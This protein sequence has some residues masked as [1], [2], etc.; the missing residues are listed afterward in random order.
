MTRAE[1]LEVF[2]RS[3]ATSEKPEGLHA[4]WISLDLPREV[5][6]GRDFPVQCEVRNDGSAIWLSQPVGQ[7]GWVGLGV[8]RWLD[9]NGDNVPGLSG[10]IKVAHDIAPRRS[11]V[12]SGMVRAPAKPGLYTCKLD[13]ISEL[14]A[15]FEEVKGSTPLEVSVKVK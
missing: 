4:S 5:W 1:T 15:W 3:L 10:R 13:M 14:V 11:V 2:G 6:A 12:L 7:K 8:V 9:A